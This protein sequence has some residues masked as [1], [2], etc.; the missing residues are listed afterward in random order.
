MVIGRGALVPSHYIIRN[1]KT[2]TKAS[3][4]RSRDGL[5]T[6]EWPCSFF[7]PYNIQV[8]AAD[9]HRHIL[10]YVWAASR[11]AEMLHLRSLYLKMEHWCTDLTLS[12]YIIFTLDKGTKERSSSELDACASVCCVFHRWLLPR[13]G[14]T[15]W[16]RQG[17]G[18]VPPNYCFLPPSTEAERGGMLPR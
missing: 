17:V 8:Y 5:P 3:H 18:L 7:H 6:L 16:E 2:K 11:I 9:C 13:Y 1:P 15:A 12:H 14:N 4:Q 10:L